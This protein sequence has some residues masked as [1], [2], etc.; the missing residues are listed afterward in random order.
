MSAV[1]QF[2]E[3]KKRRI[4]EK[5]W[6]QVEEKIKKELS[7]RETDAFRKQHE[8]IWREV[9]RQVYMKAPQKKHNDPQ[10]K[11]DWHSAIELGELA[12]SSEIITADVMRLAFPTARAW[13]EAHVEL[14]P[15]L[16]QMTGK[17]I[18]N[19]KD[20]IFIDGTV[21]AFMAQQHIDFGLKSRMSLSVKEALHHGSFVVEV[22]KEDA[23]MVHEG[24]GIQSVSAPVWV[25]HSMWNCY[26]DPSPSVLGTNMFYTG[27]MIIKEYMPRYKLNE[28]ASKGT[29]NGWMA[30]QLKK[31]P[32]RKN[33]NKDVETD[34]IEL[35]KYFGD[36]VIDRND[37][38][39]FLPNSKVI[40]ANGVL[41]FY[42]PNK[43]P[44]GSII[45]NGYEKLDVRDP[46]FTSPIIKNAP[47]HK[48]ATVLTNK[49][50]NIVALY[51]EPPLLYD[52][53]DPSFVQSGG[54]VI[55]PGWRGATK[56]TAEFKTLE[57]GDPRAVLEGL[58]F[59]IENIK[60]GTGGDASRVALDTSDKT[61]TESR[62][63]A[64]RG[65]VRVVDFVDKLE[66]SLKTFLYMQHEINKQELSVYGFY[67]PEMDAPDFMR[68]T[69]DEL[70]PN[71]HFDVVGSKGILGEEERSQKMSVVTAFASQN[72]MFS[73]L[74]KPAE[75]LKEMYQDAGVKNPERF[76]NIPDDEMA[77]M[78]SMIR[79]QFEQALQEKD[80]ENF[81]L[82]KQLA[83]TKAVN[84]ARVLEA[85]IKA[86]SQAAIAEYK[87]EIQAQIDVL[88]AQLKVA[89]T[90]TKQAGEAQKNI[91]QVSV[92]EIAEVIGA[93]EKLIDNEKG[94]RETAS[95]DMA[96]KID[97]LTSTTETLLKEIK[98]PVKLKDAKGNVL[99]TASRD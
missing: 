60:K 2:P 46:Y 23:M 87:A 54:P 39:I 62:I 91:N 34:D 73:P 81:E 63:D 76:L 4:L 66:F 26:P 24:S 71:V 3:I 57:I 19:Q 21:R 53:N 9:D 12:K 33:T 41:V 55:A 75:I 16:D 77:Q 31:I 30:S 56:G 83:I 44:M 11:N 6:K 65:E 38:D 29:E 82:Q 25:P 74:I 64:M 84:D 69:K 79:A 7:R 51:G 70:P 52:G 90:V 40:L 50:L 18:A 88:K 92:K 43:M 1:L 36:C 85:Q 32:K 37:G 67:N 80:A 99:K 96:Q 8:K 22:R 13:F 28:L 94:E 47:M 58:Q 35:V 89:E 72:P 45:Y 42:A 86:D 14:P 78:E 68:M 98:K 27:S 59:V 93:L 5:D 17:N 10:A 95:K 49:Y 48:V 97:T 20:Q 15:M 61:A